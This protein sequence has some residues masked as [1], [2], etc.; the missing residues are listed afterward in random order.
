[1]WLNLKRAI[2]SHLADNYVGGNV[3]IL[4]KIEVQFYV[5]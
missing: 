3:Y 4:S 2:D 1:M 5:I